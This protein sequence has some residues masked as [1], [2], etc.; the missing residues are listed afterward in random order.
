M[1]QSWKLIEKMI[2]SAIHWKNYNKDYV[3]NVKS[4]KLRMPKLNQMI[5]RNKILKS[6]KLRIM[7]ENQ[8]KSI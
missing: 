6:T 4:L 3:H 1:F 5:K 7:K 2:E 8:L